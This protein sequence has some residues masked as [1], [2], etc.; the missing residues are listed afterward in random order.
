M[1]QHLEH[2][3]GFSKLKVCERRGRKWKVQGKVQ[4]RQWAG[5]RRDTLVQGLQHCGGYSKLKKVRGAGVGELVA[6][7][8]RETCWVTTAALRR[9][10]KA[11]KGV[12]VGVRAAGW[13]SSHPPFPTALLPT[14]PH[15]SSSLLLSTGGAAQVGGD[16]RTFPAHRYLSCSLLPSTT[17][18]AAQ[19]CR[20]HGRRARDGVGTQSSVQ[21]SGPQRNRQGVNALGA[22]AVGHR[23]QRRP[24][25]S[26]KLHPVYRLCTSTALSW[27]NLV[28]LES[29]CFERLR[30]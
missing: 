5:E 14:H 23:Q 17:G 22:R 26:C 1:V 2:Y 16:C 28:C 9:L 24:S 11:E 10:P 20:V 25:L 21:G 4:H 30:D 27:W 19:G 3:G 18:G 15:P 6:G 12:R 8:G 13:F 7:E 29:N